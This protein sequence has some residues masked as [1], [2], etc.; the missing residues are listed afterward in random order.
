MVTAQIIDLIVFAFPAATFGFGGVQLAADVTGVV[1]IT[2]WDASL[3][4]APE[5]DEATQTYPALEAQRSACEV[6]LE[7]ASRQWPALDFLKRFTQPER[8]AIAEA[9]RTD[10]QIADFRLL[11]S[12][13]PIVHA[14]DP[15][16]IA[17]MAYLVSA[18]V[19]TEERRKEIIGEV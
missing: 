11:A 8:I 14:G 3:G 10:A 7:L 12:A 16:T 19:L 5:W 13:A 6:A 15:L 2:R 9:A 1:K 17:G 4:P 18:G